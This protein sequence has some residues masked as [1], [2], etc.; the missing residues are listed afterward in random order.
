MS[1]KQHTRLWMIHI[2]EKNK[3]F[4]LELHVVI[5]RVLLSCII[6][7]GSC[8]NVIAADAVRWLKTELKPSPYNNLGLMMRCLRFLKAAWLNI[9]WEVL[10]CSYVLCSSVEALWLYNCASMACWSGMLIILHMLT[11]TRLSRVIV[12]ILLLVI[13]LMCQLCHSLRSSIMV[14]VILLTRR[15]WVFVRGRELMGWNYLGAVY[16]AVEANLFGYSLI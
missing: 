2:Y 7:T 14:Y 4:T 1:C 11:P 15:S 10:W 12:V 3:S 6:D 9:S 16:E 13:V 8:T 5:R